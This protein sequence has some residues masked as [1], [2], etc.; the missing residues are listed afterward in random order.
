MANYTAN[1]QLKGHEAHTHTVGTLK[2]V[3]RKEA[4]SLSKINEL[5]GKASEIAQEVLLAMAVS[6]IMITAAYAGQ[7]QASKENPRSDYNKN[8]NTSKMLAMV[9]VK[10]K[11]SGYLPGTNNVSIKNTEG[12]RPY[13]LQMP[14]LE[15]N[16]AYLAPQSAS[17]PSAKGSVRFS[18]LRADNPPNYYDN[19]SRFRYEGMD[20]SNIGLSPLPMNVRDATAAYFTYVIKHKGFK[21]YSEHSSSGQLAITM[22][23]GNHGALGFYFSLTF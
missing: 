8:A 23:K 17:E 15:K 18:I 11:S 21:L 3:L 14:I 6:G 5:C 12:K 10:R 20:D 1:K 13:M 22:S 7:N 2:S 19:I 4:D 9:E 16:Y